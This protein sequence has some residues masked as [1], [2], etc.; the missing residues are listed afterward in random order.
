MYFATLI[1]TK[2]ASDISYNRF[3]P[4]KEISKAAM[5]VAGAL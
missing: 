3:V 1:L 4:I 2:K 5:E